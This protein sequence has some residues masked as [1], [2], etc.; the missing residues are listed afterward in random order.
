MANKIILKKSAVASKVPTTSD[1]D[2]GELA[3]NY[4]D[5]ILYYKNASNIISAL[6]TGGGG[7][8]YLA[9]DGLSLTGTTF[10][11]DS[12]VVRTTGS[13]ANPAWIT[14]LD[15]SKLSGTV[16]TWN[17]NTTGN[18][19]TATTLQTSRN[20]NG[21][22]FNG[23]ADITTANWGTS[24]TI[25]IGNTGKSVNGSAAVSWSL[26]EIGAYAAT[27]PS[28]YISGNQ[29]ITLSG[30]IT[31][32]GTTA[33]TTTLASVGTAGTY[34]K[35]TTDAKGRV[36]SGTTLSASDI[37][38]LDAGKITSGTFNVARIPNLDA[39]KITSGIIDAARL[40]SFV[41]D[42]LEFANLGSF[43]TTGET[44]KIYIA[45]DTNKAYRWSGT[46]YIYITSGAVDSVNAGNAITVSSTTGV[47]TVNHADTSSVA[48]VDNSGN[49]FIQDL[50][51]DTYGHVIGVVSGTAT[52]TDTN[53]TYIL[54][55]SGTTNSVNLEL[56]AGGSG[57][58]TDTINF[59]GAG[60]NT[61]SWDEANQRITITGAGTNIAEG[62]RTTTTV[63]ITSSTGTGATLSAATTSL[64]GVMSSADKTKLDGIATG[65]T[66]NTGTVTSVGGTGTVSGL[67]LSGT[68]TTSGNLT[69]GGT[70]S[71][72]PSNFAS[73]TANTFLAA[74]N[75]TSGTPTF[76]TLVAADVPTL[77][78]NTTGS[79]ATLTTGRTI[80]MTGDVTWTSASFNGSANVTGT[81]T[82]ANSGV[83]AG[84]YTAASVTV[85][86]KGRVTSAS[87]NTIPT[88]NNA[89]LTLNT[90]GIATGSQTWTANQ[91][92]AAT[93]TVNVPG[94]NIAEGT[95]TT[96]TVPITS[97]TG[98]SASLSAATT[99]LAG[100]MSSADKT[101]L[102]GIATGATANTGT[103]TSIATNNGLTGGT[104]TTTGTIGLTG[105]ALALHNLATNGV[106]VRTGSGTVAARS[107]A[108]SGTGLSVSNADGVSGNPTVTSNA[109]S[110][111]TV[112]TI[113]ARDGSGNFSAGIVTVVD[114]NSTSDERLKTNWKPLPETFL[115]EL[116]E[117]KH[118]IY[119]RTDIELTQA[120]VSAQ[121]LQKVLKEVVTEDENG[122][123]SVSYGNAA[124][125]AVIE[126]TK[127][128]KEQQK[129][130]EE[131]RNL[132]NK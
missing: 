26:S 68:V 101:K 98:S 13:Y 6:S 91:G 24:R 80:G 74:P 104:I 28:G 40:P 11:V 76:R 64:A 46:V 70:L 15:Y 47:V 127:L 109:T 19:A 123:L 112:S 56:I 81:S 71:V 90:S 59:V 30:D 111:N 116:C 36:T 34:T 79:A 18:A 132:L 97:S 106:I 120:G 122:M 63:P 37:P 16:P 77:N 108:V 86:A 29:T 82:L 4:A 14:S 62:T 22:S 66:A 67:T 42:V 7:S 85:D 27:N 130:I 69:L 25:T 12:S 100:V 115:D 105:Q 57:S 102:D 48:N 73:Q 65:A 54:D 8:E 61:V 75:G 93:F 39:S 126:L 9:G 83:T 114:L 51:F 35:V 45:L 17:Q 92:T 5:G 94:T 50:T 1:L 55:G 124:L 96:T 125:V 99:S 43:P 119:D 110:A 38:N 88:V 52:F 44:G 118:G 72:L 3:L 113:V 103:V 60:V 95:R 21:T 53:T 41:D 31:G 129:Q 87:S 2:Y 10:A 20:I 23:S 117:V 131:L 84:T 49:T 89:T 107:I 121:S 33:I 32:S 78:Q 58:G 128:V